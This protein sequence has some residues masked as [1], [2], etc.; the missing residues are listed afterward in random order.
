LVLPVIQVMPSSTP[1]LSALIWETREELP[2][3][4]PAT[5][6][7]SLSRRGI[8]TI[9][10]LAG[11]GG[12]SGVPALSPVDAKLVRILDAH[13][14]LYELSKDMLANAKL[15]K[16]GFVTAHRIAS[17]TPGE[18]RTNTAEILS[19]SE[20]EAV[21]ANALAISRSGNDDALG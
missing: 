11:L 12:L 21:R 8:T 1:T 17:T 7:S 9:G 6:R 19:S 2:L 13:L 10:Q 18:F 15:I 20:A 16:K 4:L 3:E 5:V 14:Q